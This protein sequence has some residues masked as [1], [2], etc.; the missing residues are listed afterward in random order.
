MPLERV[1]V[2]LWKSGEVSYLQTHS[3]STRL[4]EAGCEKGTSC[5]Q[6]G[7]SHGLALLLV[8][9]FPA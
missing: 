3:F 8:F 1:G 4:V 6:Y 9:E 7:S 5:R 2:N